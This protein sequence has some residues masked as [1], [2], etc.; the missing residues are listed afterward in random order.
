MFI[1]KRNG[2]CIKKGSIFS[3]VISYNLNQHFFAM[4]NKNKSCLF[5]SAKTETTWKTTLA[6][7]SQQIFILWEYTVF[8]AS[9]LYWTIWIENYVQL[10]NRN[11]L[12]GRFY[13]NYM[14]FRDETWLFCTS[15]FFQK[16]VN[17]MFPASPSRCVAE[18]AIY[19]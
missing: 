5:T 12:I 17:C 13:A 9:M 7:Y 15:L 16:L 10:H 14:K 2:L 19:L 3:W 1:I 4:M 11:Q 18:C 6:S 8:H